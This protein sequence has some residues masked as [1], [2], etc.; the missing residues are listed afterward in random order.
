MALRAYLAQH[1]I[2]HTTA[3]PYSKNQN[4]IAGRANRTI[5]ECARSMLDQAG[6]PRTL[7]PEAAGHAA[8][9]RN[10]FLSPR[11]RTKTSLEIMTGRKPNVGYFRVFGYLGW[12]HVPKD[13][14][15][16]LGAMSEAG[17]VIACME[18]SHYKLWIASRKVAVVSRDVEIIE[19]LFPARNWRAEN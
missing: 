9:I 19:T 18:N 6:L 2:E 10:S 8:K 11:N 1:G 12:H 17:T 15:K 7:W 16:K 5:V 4:G 14:R 13:L 3:P